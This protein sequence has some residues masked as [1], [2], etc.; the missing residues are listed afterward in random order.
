MA[1]RVETPDGKTTLRR[2][3]GTFHEPIAGDGYDPVVTAENNLLA[4]LADAMAVM[5]RG[6]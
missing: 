5:V 2:G 4:Q 6:R 1:W 3:N